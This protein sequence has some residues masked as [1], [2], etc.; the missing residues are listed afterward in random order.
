VAS[1]PLTSYSVT[2]FTAYHTVCT[3]DQHAPPN[4]MLLEKRLQAARDILSPY[5]SMDRATALLAEHR[6]TH[7]IVNDRFPANVRID[8]WSMN[9]EMFPAMREKFDSHPEAFEEVYAKDGFVVFRWNGRQVEPDSAFS[10][11]F[12]LAAVPDEMTRVGKEA[13]EAVLEGFALSENSLSPGRPL[14]IG[15]VWSGRGEYPFRNYAVAVRFDHTNPGLPLGG[16]PFP[17]LARKIKEKLTGRSYRFSE[18]HKIRSGFLSPDTWRR[19]ELALDETRLHIPSN[20]APGEYTV[21]IK[22]LTLQHQ[23]TYRL[24]DIFS[25]DDVYAGLP[26]VRITIR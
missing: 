16:K 26:V 20:A 15:L 5:V 11:P 1:D 7:V 13:G 8:Y 9:H 24:K 18:F 4:D 6:A 12:I 17:K 23:Q 25:D 14:D 2:A 3:F 19:G 10:T 21:S 22:L